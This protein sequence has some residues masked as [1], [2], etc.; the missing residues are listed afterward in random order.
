MKHLERFLNNHTL[1]YE[2]AYELL[3]LLDS[4]EIVEILKTEAVR[5]RKLNYGNKVYCRGLIEFTNYCR[6]NCYYCGIRCGN[7]SLDR[8]RM[9]REEILACCREGYKLG[10]RTFVLQGGED[11]WFSRERMASIIESIRDRYPDCAITLSVGE[12]SKETYRVWKEA[13]ADRYLLRHET[14]DDS[15]YRMLHPESMSLERRKENSIS[16]RIAEGGLG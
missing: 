5:L 4:P 12:R 11:P 9:S 15:H 3:G 10:Y 14:A 16:W 8:Y 7:T 2:E 1:N 13:G 6:N